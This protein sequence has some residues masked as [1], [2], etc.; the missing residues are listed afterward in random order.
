MSENL[1]IY[2]RIHRSDSITEAYVYSRVTSSPARIDSKSQSKQVRA[3][4]NYLENVAV[5]VCREVCALL[6][7]THSLKQGLILGHG[8]GGSGG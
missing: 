5:F 7:N 3:T 2:L 6:N 1:H 8:H 4:Q